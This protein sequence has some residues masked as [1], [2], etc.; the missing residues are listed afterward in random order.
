MFFKK[1]G[2]AVVA[3]AFLVVAA[4]AVLVYGNRT[5]H[6]HELSLTGERKNIPLLSQHSMIHSQTTTETIS[7]CFQWVCL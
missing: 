5:E 7:K 3:V 6:Y 1:W 2:V 4:I